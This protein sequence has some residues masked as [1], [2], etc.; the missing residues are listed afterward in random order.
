MKNYKAA[1][2]KAA[3]VS[4]TEAE[5]L[6]EAEAA[7]EGAFEQLRREEAAHAETRKKLV[8]HQARPLL[9]AVAMLYTHV[10]CICLMNNLSAG[11]M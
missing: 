9:K 3:L 11:S 1:A 8:P 4:A 5:R 7:L 6:R 10:S 2:S